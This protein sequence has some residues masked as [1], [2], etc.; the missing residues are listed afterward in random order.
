MKKKAPV[1]VVAG[2][3]AGLT[4]G[5]LGVASAAPAT[6][7]VTGESVGF[8]LRMGSAIHDAGARMADILA[9]LTG[10]AADDITDRRADGESIADIAADEG[11]D[12]AN[13]V[14]EATSVREQMLDERV[15]DGTITAEDKDTILE[16]MTSR[17]ADRVESTDVGGYGTGGGRGG[18]GGMGGSG[19]GGGGYCGGT[20]DG[21][22][23]AAP[24]T[25]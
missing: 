17:M 5:S 24:A 8:G 4:L 22:G 12:V 20:C 23:V 18:R 19:I 14:D 16:Q 15:A 25:F 9:D 2:L 1:W 6:D 3:V 11:V 7:P 13:V 10:L 21:T